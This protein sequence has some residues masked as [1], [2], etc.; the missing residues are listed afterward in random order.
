MKD[1]QV[2][3]DFKIVEDDE[4]S[5]QT[6][7]TYDD[8]VNERYNYDSNV[9][10]NKRV[11]EGD[12]VI[13]R[14]K[15]IILGVSIID[16]IKVLDGKKPI[17]YCPVCSSYIIEPRKFK[18]PKFRCDRGHEFDQPDVKYKDIK[19][20][21]AYYS[22][23]FVPLNPLNISISEMRK[24]YIGFN[25]TNSINRLNGLV[26]N[27]LLGITEIKSSNSIKNYLRPEDAAD[28][29]DDLDDY[30]SSGKDERDFVLRQIK[31][32]RGQSKFRNALR[33][34]YGDICMVTGC[35]ILDILEAAHINPYLG[36]NDNN[37]SNGLLLRADIHTLFDL[38]LIG[39]D[40]DTL[41]VHVH[42]IA[43]KSYGQFH[44]CPL[45]T[46]GRRKPSL[47]ALKKRW[48]DFSKNIIP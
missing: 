36:T 45:N 26:L 38:N 15:K 13:I 17:Q 37:P 9:P 32:R 41:L 7:R 27:E 34:R 12:Y 14:N 31:A 44:L 42:K 20:Y 21:T 22:N 35:N 28:L 33:K 46:L 6:V 30:V 25:P 8:K 11:K 39:I 16:H 47:E 4:R 48:E 10:N 24:Y 1:S 43:M 19:I 3:Y 18:R 2:V 29:N 40:P 23:H 5:F